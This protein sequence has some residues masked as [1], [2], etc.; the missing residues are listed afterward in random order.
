[1]SFTNAL[2]EH[3]P[4]AKPESEYV[5][6]SLEA[7]TPHGFDNPNTIACVAV[8]RDELTRPFA[9]LVRKTWGEAFSLGSLGGMVL[10]GRTGFL[11]AMHHA[12][13]IGGRQRY[14]FFAMAHIGIGDDG[15][16][17]R[18]WRKGVDEP[19]GACGALLAFRS[20]LHSGDLRVELDQDDVE[21]SL[22]KQRLMRRLKYGYVPNLSRLTFLTHEVIIHDLERMLETAVDPTTSNYG[23][24]TG[25]QIHGPDFKTWI[26]PGTSYAIV[27]SVRHNLK[28]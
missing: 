10:L 14:A 24:F 8:C 5:A 7:L 18:C 23:V 16:I 4:G 11:A 19:S 22:L 1:M 21:F 15:E 13:T 26:W 9:A 25:I 27:N 28:I 17:G 6:W 20:E 2:N 3:F 12:P